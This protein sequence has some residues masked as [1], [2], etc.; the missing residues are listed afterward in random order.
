MQA[1]R[2]ESGLDNSPMY[3]GTFFAKNLSAS[4]SLLH[5][6]MELYDVG[7]ASMCAQRAEV[8]A[9]EAEVARGLA[10]LTALSG[11]AE[12]QRQKL[13]CAYCRWDRQPRHTVECCL[14][15]PGCCVCG[16]AHKGRDCDHLPAD[17]KAVQE[18]SAKRGHGPE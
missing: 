11:M 1:A 12:P 18:A 7:F 9:I 14:H 3:D 17:M 10:R 16:Q 15:K 6:A 5:G 2:Y 13:S 8:F 4:G